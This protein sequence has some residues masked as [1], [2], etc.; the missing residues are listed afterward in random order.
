LA[1]CVVSAPSGVDLSRL[2]GELSREPDIDVFDLE[3]DFLIP[4]VDWGD[5]RF[6]LD[7]PHDMA[8]VTQHYTREEVLACWEKGLRKLVKTAERYTAPV[9]VLGCHLSLFSARRLEFY[10]TVPHTEA[11]ELLSPHEPRRIIG[12]ID[13]LF[14]MY[15]RLA[16]PFGSKEVPIFSE[17]I[18]LE[19]YS[20]YVAQLANMDRDRLTEE[21]YEFLRIETRLKTLG[22]L[23]SWRRMELLAAESL[24]R[25]L[26]VPFT[27]FGSKNSYEGLKSLIREPGIRTAYISHKITE[28]RLD[29]RTRIAEGSAQRWDRLAHDVHRISDALIRQGIV[30]IEP[31]AIDE[32]RFER[33]EASLVDQG[34]TLGERW[35]IPHN[36]AYQRPRVPGSNSSPPDYTD[37]F[38]DIE[39]ESDAYRHGTAC[40]VRGFE[41]QVYEEI[42]FRDH[43][44]VSSNS[45]LLIF[46]PQALIRNQLGGGVKKELQHWHDS[47]SAESGHR[48]RAAIIHTVDD[49]L[50]TLRFMLE[51]DPGR[52]SF[53]INESARAYLKRTMG[54]EEAA[55]LWRNKRVE[56][57]GLPG[58][59]SRENGRS[60]LQLAASAA[61]HEL[62]MEEVSNIPFEA[63][64]Y[65]MPFIA[66]DDEGALDNELMERVAGWLKGE[67]TPPSIDPEVYNRL[68]T[69]TG[70]VD[71]LDFVGTLAEEPLEMK[72]VLEARV[73]GG[74]EQDAG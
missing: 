68:Y 48:R 30:A 53:G 16:M 4:E 33:E 8:T 14:D 12:V 32:L 15:A 61:M 39:L 60:R 34:L 24:A 23:L 11:W 67:S 71:V 21:D 50:E 19:D 58:T 63:L 25:D 31:T 56:P 38:S 45:C 18:Q 64:D 6:E 46:R 55:E 51:K 37:L 42:A 59:S 2:L 17:D 72:S 66:L 41:A 52:V 29:N 22:R 43:L 7:P 36:A 28:P 40:L 62:V 73:V 5:P 47:L 13:D 70:F 44:L 9:K 1:L 35:P 57:E 74:T 69:A 3:N 54:P 65:A 49:V 10:Y 20:R 27:A 26:G